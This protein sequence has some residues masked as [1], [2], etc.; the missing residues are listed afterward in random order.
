MRALPVDAL[1]GRPQVRALPVDALP[2]RPQVRAFPVDPSPI[3]KRPRPITMT[4]ATGNPA[5]ETPCP[6]ARDFRVV[7][8]RLAL[9]PADNPHAFRDQPQMPRGQVGL[10]DR[11]VGIVR[12][13]LG[14]GLHRSPEVGDKMVFVVDRLNARHVGPAEQH[15]ARPEKRLDVVCDETKP[16]PYV[17]RNA[18]FSAKI[19]KGRL[20]LAAP[21]NRSAVGVTGTRAGGATNRSACRYAASILRSAMSK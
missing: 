15:G 9:A 18:R 12:N 14:I 2:G 19:G 1:P 11:V 10:V 6:P 21:A 4:P 13:G 17:C 8:V 3:V 16:R 5:A 7:K 20:H